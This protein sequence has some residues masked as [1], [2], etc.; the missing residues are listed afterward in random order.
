MENKEKFYYIYELN[1]NLNEK[2]LRKLLLQNE[3]E[4]IQN[5]I[6]DYIDGDFD[7]VAQCETLKKCFTLPLE[8]I[9]NELETWHNYSI[10][11][12]FY[13]TYIT[14]ITFKPSTTLEKVN[15][16]IQTIQN[17][18]SRDYVQIKG[19]NIKFFDTYIKSCSKG[20]CITLEH[21]SSNININDIEYMLDECDEILTFKYQYKK[22]EV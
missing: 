19:Q 13:N 14:N 17:N 11:E 2:E 4:H 10:S 7:I 20:Y 21:R 6:T 18:F 9:I 15:E 16:I 22:S 3:V 1:E 8:N 12:V 5:N